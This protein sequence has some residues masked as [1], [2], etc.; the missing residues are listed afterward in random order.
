MM[1]TMMKQDALQSVR[2]HKSLHHS[3][4]VFCARDLGLA[5]LGLPESHTV[6]I[7]SFA[8]MSHDIIL[9]Y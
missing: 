3:V 2:N 5:V 7:F 1:K 6:T 9:L 8:L 4:S